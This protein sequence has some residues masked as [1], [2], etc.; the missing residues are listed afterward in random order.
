MGGQHMTNIMKTFLAF[1]IV[2]ALV[3]PLAFVSGG[4]SGTKKREVDVSAG[5]YYGEDEI[6]ELSD[7]KK[8]QYCEEI[9]IE[10][11]RTQQEFEAKTQELK[12]TR[13]AIDAT[14]LAID[15]VEREVLRLEAEIR[16]LNDLISEVKALPSTWTV[17]DGESMSL[18]AS[19]P[20]VYNDVEK[21]WKIFEANQDKVDD[22]FYVFP[23]TV[24]VIP[25]DW[26]TD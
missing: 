13:E 22:P 10:L 19:F 9:G 15:P 11:T 20:E 6:A 16:T 4:C 2:A 12:D 3:A 25:R 18:I 1:V 24:L 8:N 21:W 7:K 23:D 5:E 14:R 26:P 17:K